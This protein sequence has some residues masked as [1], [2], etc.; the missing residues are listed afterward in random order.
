MKKKLLAMLLVSTT[1]VTVA[2]SSNN[3]A[4]EEGTSNQNNEEL[5]LAISNEPADGFDPV[6][7]W[8]KY[9]APLFQSTLFRYDPD[10]NLINDIGVNYEIS[11]DL[12]N[13]TIEIREDVRYSDDTPF[14]VEDIIYTFETIKAANSIIDLQNVKAIEKLDETHVVFQLKKP[15]TTFAHILATTGLFSEKHYSDTYNQHPIGTGP[16]ILEQWDKGEKVILT[17]N[18]NYYGEEPEIKKLT[19][20][21]LNEETAI[22]SAKKEEIDVLAV[23]AQNADLDIPGM[24]LQTFD[25]VDNRGIALPVIKETTRDG[26]KV[27]N[28][29]TTNRSIRQAMNIVIDRDEMVSGVLNGFGTR[30]FSVADQLPWWNEKSVFE[31]NQLDKAKAILEKDGWEWDKDGKLF[32]GEIEATIDLLYP[33]GDPVREALALTF[34]TQVAPL[35]ITVNTIGESWDYLEKEFNANPTLM[36]WGSNTPIEMYNIYDSSTIG[37]G[38]YNINYYQNDQ[39]ENYFDKALSSRDLDEANKYWKLAQWDGEQGFATE[40]GDVPWIWLVNVQ[41]LYYM[42]DQLNIGEQKIQPHGHG[43]AITDFINEWTLSND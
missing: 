26:K 39:V 13:W 19:F 5:V 12:L 29:V 30:A 7:G 33:S 35:G 14:K 2:C 28:D 23:S 43:W 36:G 4:K 27:G 40:E 37:K 16:Y 17:P 8:G 25:S 38:M 6:N 41:H 20:L 32:K 31:D 34:K 24:T 11:E 1:V 22:A 21:F 3:Q 10:F 42:N 15:D 18:P 9:G